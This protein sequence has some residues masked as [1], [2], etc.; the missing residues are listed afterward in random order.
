MPGKVETA[1]SEIGWPVEN[2]SV[3]EAGESEHVENTLLRR[4]PLRHEL[5][6]FHRLAQIQIGVVVGV[7][8]EAF[9]IERI[10]KLRYDIEP[11]LRAPQMV[12][13][14]DHEHKI[15]AL[16]TLRH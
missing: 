15:E 14:C 13:E 12:E 10:G 8:Q 11:Q 6:A 5:N 16:I 4:Y 1:I 7:V 2:C 3:T 9:Q